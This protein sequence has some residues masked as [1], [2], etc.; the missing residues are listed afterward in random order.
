MYL[1]INFSQMLECRIKVFP[2]NSP[3]TA[4]DAIK[5][6]VHLMLLSQP[7]KINNSI[8]LAI[9]LIIYYYKSINN[10]YNKTS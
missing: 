3:N 8:T 1:S 10:L 2:E 4:F 7:I 5:Y 6:N 9:Q